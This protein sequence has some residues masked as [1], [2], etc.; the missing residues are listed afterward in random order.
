MRLCGYSWGG[1]LGL[2]YTLEHPEKVARL[3]L[4]SPAAPVHTYRAAM[5]A[6]LRERAARTQ[7]LGLSGFARAVAGYFAHP[8][9][10]RELTPFRVQ[11]RAEQSVL[12]SL[13]AYDLRSQLHAIKQRVLVLH[14]TEDPIPLRYSQELVQLLP[15]AR[16][17]VLPGSGH[18][19]YIEAPQIFFDQLRNF[20]GAQ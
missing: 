20:F 9:R 17:L 1:L 13:G 16:L 11:M 4:C 2:L 12:E 3:A 15:N 18:V 6:T 8:E 10:A 7:A 14:G 5:T 19:P